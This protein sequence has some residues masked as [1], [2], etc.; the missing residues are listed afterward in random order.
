MHN[1]DDLRIFLAV[2]RHKS[3]QGASEALGMDATTIARRVDRL[4]V[5][6]KSTLLTR[7]RDGQSLTSTG[8]RI[9]DIVSRMELVDEELNKEA[10]SGFAGRVRLSTSEGFGTAILSPAV[11]DLMAQTPPVEIEIVANPGFLSPVMREVDL[12]ITLAAPQDSRLAIEKLTDY[13]LGLYA[14]PHYVAKAGLP[15]NLAELKDHILVGYIDDLLYADELRYLD[16]LPGNLR[17]RIAS[18]SIRA[19]L[20]IVQCGAGIAILPCFMAEIAIPPLERILSPTISITRTFWMSARRDV[21]KTVRVR[22]VRNWIH[23][24]VARQKKLILPG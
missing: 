7:G 24:T 23:R 15:R 1:W 11:P 16:D 4:E 13:R 2:A 12:A 8:R 14:S 6:L 5:A 20:E 21:Q 3:Y 22:Q 19:Q 10:N 9:L 17:P 18:S